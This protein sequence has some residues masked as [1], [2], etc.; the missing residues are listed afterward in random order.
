MDKTDKEQITL[1]LDGDVNALSTLVERYRRPLFS[2][3]IKMTEGRDDADELFQETWVR[4]IKHIHTYEDRRLCSW[5][6]R[7]AHNLIIDRARRRKDEIS[8]NQ[9]DEHERSLSDVLPGGSP[10]PSDESSNRDLMERI[11]RAVADLPDDQKVVFLM[12]MEGQLP[13]KEIARMQGTSINTALGR[14]QYALNKLR[15]TLA[16]DYALLGRN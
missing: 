1:Y 3:I 6:F 14:M 16:E 7:I 13:F 10:T 9:E 8:L 4:A 2:F 11:K 15:S 5:L 12:R